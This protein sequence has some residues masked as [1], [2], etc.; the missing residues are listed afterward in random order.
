MQQD[1]CCLQYS[2]QSPTL[3]QQ[4]PPQMHATC[5]CTPAHQDPCCQVQQASPPQLQSQLPLAVQVINK[6]IF[7]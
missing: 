6:N 7:I 2:Q 3:P 1:P 4:E 5:V